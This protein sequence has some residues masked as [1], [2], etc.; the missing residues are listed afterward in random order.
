MVLKFT[1]KNLFDAYVN[2]LQ[3][4]KIPTKQLESAHLKTLMQFSHTRCYFLP[5]TSDLDI[6]IRNGFFKTVCQFTI[7]DN[8]L[9]DDTFINDKSDL[10]ALAIE[11][12]PLTPKMVEILC[13][14]VLRPRYSWW[15]KER[16]QEILN[17]NTSFKENF[18]LIACQN[19]I[20]IPQT[21][22]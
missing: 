21:F 4:Q 8:E 9:K 12:T 14:M 11:H 15:L 16:V 6:L 5:K 18:E 1:K 19:S 3:K 2:D 20:D 13:Q 22:R 10:I 7:E 17:N